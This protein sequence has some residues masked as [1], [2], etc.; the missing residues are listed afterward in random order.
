MFRTLSFLSVGGILSKGVDTPALVS[1]TY[2]HRQA[3]QGMFSPDMEW[4]YK[5]LST[6]CSVLLAPILVLL[7]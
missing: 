5:A 2:C 4:L 6:A 1:L 3:A 7:T